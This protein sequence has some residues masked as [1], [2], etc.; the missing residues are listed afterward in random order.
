MPTLQQ[1]KKKFQSVIAQADHELEKFKEALN[2]NPVH[3]FTWAEST[4]K[5]AAQKQV[6]S[7]YLTHINKW[8]EAQ[9]TGTLSE[10]QPQTAEAVVEHLYGFISR[11]AINKNRFTNQSTSFMSNGMARYE[12]A[13]YAELAA[14]WEMLY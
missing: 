7:V 2:E 14:E 10:Q 13:F 11:E 3:A 4:M 8:E 12:A 1:V 6:A 9:V 5:L